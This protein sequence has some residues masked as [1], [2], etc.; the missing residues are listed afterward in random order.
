MSQV[1][2]AVIQTGDG[3]WPQAA[4]ALV[5]IGALLV[6]LPMIGAGLPAIYWH[7]EYNFIEGALRIG[8]A[9]ITDVSFG[10]YGHGTLTYFLL[11]GALGLFFA[12]GRLTGAFAGSDDFVQSYLLDPSAVFLVARTVML[13]ASVGV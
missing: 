5:C 4:I 8:S 11:F 6:R 7:D 9:G 10:G 13:A 12:V 2:P 1:G 3:R